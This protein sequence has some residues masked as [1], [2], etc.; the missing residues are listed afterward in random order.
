MSAAAKPKVRPYGNAYD[1]TFPNG[2]TVRI[3]Q[4]SENEW[5]WYIPEPGETTHCVQGTAWD[6]GHAMRGAWALAIKTAPPPPAAPDI[7]GLEA[8]IGATLKECDRD[9]R[10]TTLAIKRCLKA[11]WPHL[12]FSVRGSTGTAWGWI[13][14]RSKSDEG[15]AVVAVLGLGSTPSRMGHWIEAICKAAGLDRPE[16]FPLAPLD[17]D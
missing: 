12:K 1:V 14:V 7:A 11:R 4:R 17:W 16:S 9:R 10:A 3:R 8:L 6:Q 2:V 13:D 5:G 15:R